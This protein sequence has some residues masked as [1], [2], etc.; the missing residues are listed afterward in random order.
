M[1]IALGKD[2]P[3]P[4]AAVAFQTGVLGILCLLEHEIQTS[5]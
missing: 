1:E 5:V 4:V 2:L 3:F